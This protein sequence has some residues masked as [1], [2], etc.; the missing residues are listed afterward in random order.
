MNKNEKYFFDVM[1]ML[2]VIG[3]D[4][5]TC[6]EE[7]LE[8]IIGEPID[9][10]VLRFLITNERHTWNDLRKRRMPQEYLFGALKQMVKN[11]YE[12]IKHGLRVFRGSNVTDIT[13]EFVMN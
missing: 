5:N 7:E 3:I 12:L 11:K 9:Y 1:A 13:D 4:Y 6:T 10:E 2:T 8:N